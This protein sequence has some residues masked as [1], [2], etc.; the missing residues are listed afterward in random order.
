MKG[1][2]WPNQSPD[3]SMTEFFFPF[4]SIIKL[5]ADSELQ[6]RSQGVQQR[7]V[8]AAGVMPTDENVIK[9]RMSSGGLHQ[10]ENLQLSPLSSDSD[11]L[12]SC[13]HT[14][15]LSQNMRGAVPAPF[16]LL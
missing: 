3:V 4:F 10:R 2:K 12:S 8:L 9:M 15:R 7:V 11:S 1:L 13:F 16:C 5:C 6:N 14:F